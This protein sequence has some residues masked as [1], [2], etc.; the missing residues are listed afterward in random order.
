MARLSANWAGARLL[1]GGAYSE[2]NCDP[3]GLALGP[4]TD[5][6]VGCRKGR[7]PP[8]LLVQVMNRN[9]GVIIASVNGGGA[10]EA[11]AF[12]GASPR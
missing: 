3:T 8:P 4:G 1:S 7:P 11:F 5:I 10:S 2:G 12:R 9:T 6:G